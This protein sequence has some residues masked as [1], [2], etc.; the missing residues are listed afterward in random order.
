MTYEDSIEPEFRSFLLPLT[1][2]VA[3]GVFLPAVPAVLLAVASGFT[4]MPSDVAAYYR[5]IHESFLGL[6]NVIAKVKGTPCWSA[7]DLEEWRN[8]RN[9]WA[10][11]YATGPSTTWLILKDD[12]KTAG[13]YVEGLLSWRKRVAA[14]CVAKPASGTVWLGLV[15]AVGVAT[16]GWWY[17]KRGRGRRGDQ[18]I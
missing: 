12:Y 3:G 17:F 1:L 4:L 6:N 7:I 9:A 8:F 5:E 14:S 10:K 13:Q 2:G 11:F 15:L 16:A 18:L